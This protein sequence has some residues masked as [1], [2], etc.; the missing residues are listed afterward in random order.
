MQATLATAEGAAPTV[1]AAPTQL[2]ADTAP[3]AGLE[4]EDRGSRESWECPEQGTGTNH[5]SPVLDNTDM[6]WDTPEESSGNESEFNFLSNLASSL[7]DD[8]SE[9]EDPEVETDPRYLRSK[10]LMRA[11]LNPVED[12]ESADTGSTQ[13]QAWGGRAFEP[14]STA[15]SGREDPTPGPTL[16]DESEEEDLNGDP[17]P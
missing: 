17:T 2:N 6:L 10:C 16:E 11:L 9:E 14:A 8:S 3:G 15:D 4:E 12:S 7:R 13:E 5:H 1:P